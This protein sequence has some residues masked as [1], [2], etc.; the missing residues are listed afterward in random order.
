MTDE[1]RD[2]LNEAD[3]VEDAEVAE[4]PA[5]ER[6][7]AEKASAPRR[8]NRQ[9][10]AAQK[11]V[12]PMWLWVVTVILLMGGAGGVWVAKTINLKSFK[13]QHLE[14][15]NKKNQEI[16][17]LED[18]KAKVNN[19]L[20]SQVQ[21]RMNLESNYDKVQA[22]KADLQMKLTKTENDL[23]ALET[24]SSEQVSS[25]K[26]E[27]SA[28]KSNLKDAENKLNR[29]ESDLKGLRQKEKELAD[30][31]EKLESSE[32]R[33]KEIHRQLVETR[34]QRDDLDKMVKYYK[35]EKIPQMEEYI[36]ELETGKKKD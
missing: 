31:K 3:D 7:D 18:A 15:M 21:A 5:S 8:S 9:A 10:A 35:E 20:K 1:E 2:D 12:V 25:L 22:M 29:L 30:T 27:I 33:F 32:T 16:K 11:A 26:K 28:A 34:I 24:E 19:D 4:T 13:Q 36:E 17:D 6:A 14:A 23:K